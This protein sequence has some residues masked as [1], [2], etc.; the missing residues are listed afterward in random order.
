MKGSDPAALVGLAIAARRRAL[1]DRVVL[2]AVVPYFLV[3]GRAPVVYPRYLLPLVPPLVLSAARAAAELPWRRARAPVFVTVWLYSFALAASHV[4]RFSLDQQEEVARWI[5]ADAGR[6]PAR[7]VV[8]GAP[9]MPFDYF[10]LSAPV[11]AARLTYVELPDGHWFDDPPAYFVLPEWYEI[12][13][14]RDSTPGSPEA[15]DLDRL[16]SGS[17]YVAVA[18]WRSWYLQRDLYTALDPAFAGDLW[19]GE[20]GFTVY[21]RKPS[22]TP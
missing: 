22:L 9:K 15:R 10:R 6:H 1:A 16:R 7:K 11:S 14:R 19:Q 12:A 21:T 18:R 13:I 17:D 20:I 5:A 2:A 8:V 4:A 3:I